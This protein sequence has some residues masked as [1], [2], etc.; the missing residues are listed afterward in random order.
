MKMFRTISVVAFLLAI[1]ATAFSANIS[2]SVETDFAQPG[3]TI[4]IR[5]LVDT[6]IA[7]AS[8]RVPITMESPWLTL[9]R[10]DWDNSVASPSEFLDTTNLTNDNRTDWINVLPPFHAPFPTVDPPGGEICRFWIT[11]DPSAPDGFIP[12]DTWS[13]QYSWVDASDV[14]GN[15]FQPD[16]YSGGI[17]VSSPTGVEDNQVTLPTEVSLDQNRPNPFNPTT[18]IEFTLPRS[19]HVDLGVY[20]VLGRLVTSLAAGEFPAGTHQ[21]VWNSDGA[22][23]GVYFYRL[24]TERSV[25]TRKML[26]LK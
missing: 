20:D 14:L 16:F 2:M 10:V 22:P 12:I 6:D 25:L 4:Y 21:V 26:L 17:W 5:L 9:N 8:M 15:S 11:V 23:S 19:A 7:L 3:E 1:S 13:D 24:N 18:T